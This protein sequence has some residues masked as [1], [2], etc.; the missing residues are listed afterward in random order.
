MKLDVD[1]MPDAT[2]YGIGATI[3]RHSCSPTCRHLFSIA[4]IMMHSPPGYKHR[5]YNLVKKTN[6]LDYGYIFAVPRLQEKGSF[7]LASIKHA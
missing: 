3:W 7:S 6:G 5:W 4:F 2:E 1:L